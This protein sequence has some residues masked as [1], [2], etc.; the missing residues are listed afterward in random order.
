MTPK[1]NF[2]F[3]KPRRR[4]VQLSKREL[5]DLI[6]AKKFSVVLTALKNKKTTRTAIGKMRQNPKI[7]AH[8]RKERLRSRGR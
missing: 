4:P 2:K 3:V 6:L 1:K 5:R 8:I 7:K